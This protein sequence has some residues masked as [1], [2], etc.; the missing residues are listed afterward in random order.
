MET[1][2]IRE[3][4]V[5]EWLP[6]SSPGTGGVGREKE[7]IDAAVKSAKVAPDRTKNKKIENEKEA[8]ASEDSEFVKQVA[9]GHEKAIEKLAESLNRFMESMCYE[10]QFV[11]DKEE[12]RVIVKVLDGEGKLIRRIPPEGM[13]ELSSKIGSDIGLLVNTTLE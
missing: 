3:N 6:G 1:M 11:P 13:A 8:I 12:G 4:A 10:L 7:R 5:Y 9:S 2:G